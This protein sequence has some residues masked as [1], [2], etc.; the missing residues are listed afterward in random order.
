MVLSVSS[1]ILTVA[2]ARRKVTCENG[3]PCVLVL[4]GKKVFRILAIQWPDLAAGSVTG[5]RETECHDWQDGFP[6]GWHTAMLIES[7]LARKKEQWL[8]FYTCSV[9]IFLW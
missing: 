5:R 7:Y 6:E 1:V 4:P 2:K 9:V 8:V 3:Q